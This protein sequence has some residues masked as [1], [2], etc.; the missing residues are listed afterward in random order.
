MLFLHSRSLAINLTNCK[1]E[2]VRQAAHKCG[3]K[4]VG[5]EEE[6]TVYWTDCTASLDRVVEMKRFQHGLDSRKSST[7]LRANHDAQ[8]PFDQALSSHSYGDFQSYRRQQKAR[9]YICKPDSGCQ[10]HGIFI[11]QNPWE[12]KPGEHMICQQYISKVKDASGPS[13]SPNPQQWAASSLRK[14]ERKLPFL[15]D[16][17]KFDMRI[18]V[19][20]TSCDPLRIFMYEEGLAR[21]A[22]T[23]YVEPSHTDLYLSGGTC[24]CFEILGFDILLDH[25]LKPW[26]LEVNHSPSFTTDSRLDQEVKDALLCDAMTL[27]NLRACDKRKVMEEE[28]R[29]VKE[30]LFQCHQQPR[31]S[32][33]E[34]TEPSQGAMLD[35]E[36]YKD[37]YLGKYRCIYPGPDTEK[38]ACFFKHNG[39]LFQ[40][41]AASKARE[42]CARQ[43]LEEIC[44]K[45]EQQ[46]SG[47]KRQKAE[48]QNQGE[49]AGEKSQPRPGLQSLSTCLVYRNHNWEKKLLPGQLDTMRPQEIVEEEELERLKALLQREMLIRSLGI[50]EQLT[51][52]Q[53]PG[54]QGQKKL[55]ECRVMGL[56]PRCGPGLKA[57]QET[58]SPFLRRAEYPSHRLSPSED[59]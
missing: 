47:T 34:K 36:Q 10:G 23:P 2:S 6:W 40:E 38:Y 13:A 51:S 37:S 3:L 58:K 7:G 50:V 54:P 11:T 41:T 42:E 31:E 49:S 18:Y 59:R 29:Q 4:E 21:F 56:N 30:R 14:P 43:E 24:A 52:L 20:I 22:T 57:I 45:Q 39:S 15:I 19:L 44:L 35:Q 17:F 1:Y 26:L 8:K 33:K 48:D 16:G 32:R 25:K 46:N 53:H 27:V 55:H 28:K 12:I 5:E 9:T